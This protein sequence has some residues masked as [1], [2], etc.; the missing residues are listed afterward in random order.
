MMSHLNIQ[1]CLD[2]LSG[3]LAAYPSV[4]EAV[5]ARPVSGQRELELL[6]VSGALGERSAGEAVAPAVSLQV[7]V[8]GQGLI[9]RVLGGEQEGLSDVCGGV[10]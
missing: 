10:L 3:L 5:A 8:G 2:G 6:V 4:L 7:V 9:E 1:G